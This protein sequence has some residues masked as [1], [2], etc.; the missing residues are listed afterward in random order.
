MPNIFW[1]FIKEYKRMSTPLPSPSDDITI[2]K[3][4]LLK[5][6]E[7]VAWKHLINGKEAEYYKDL[8]IYLDGISITPTANEKKRFY[9]EKTMDEIYNDINKATGE[10]I[11]FS[12]GSKSEKTIEHISDTLKSQGYE[13]EML[14]GNESMKIRWI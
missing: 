3:K 8:N 14:E 4:K 10:Y 6:L 11:I 7:N 5:D 2:S 12:C 13:I 9:L 1:L